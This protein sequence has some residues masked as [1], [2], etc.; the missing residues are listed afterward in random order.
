[1]VH[2]KNNLWYIIKELLHIQ[3]FMWPVITTILMYLY[4]IPGLWL[5]NAVS[6]PRLKY[7][8]MFLEF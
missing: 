2:K 1:M 7:H 5:D 4:N 3:W 6:I 8:E